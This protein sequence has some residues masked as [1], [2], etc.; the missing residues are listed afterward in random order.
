MV[1]VPCLRRG[2]RCLPETHFAP[3]TQ[4]LITA[5]VERTHGPRLGA[6]HL[7]PEEIVGSPPLCGSM[8]RLLDDRKPR[9]SRA[10]AEGREGLAILIIMAGLMLAG[11]LV[12][13]ACL[14]K[15]TNK[16]RHRV[17]TLA[18]NLR[19]TPSGKTGSTSGETVTE[20]ITLEHPT[21][22]GEAIPKHAIKKLK[23]AP[24]PDKNKE[25]G[26]K[27]KASRKRR[28]L[29]AR[30]KPTKSTKRRFEPTD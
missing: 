24:H 17:L 23:A 6:M 27:K 26:S 21:I 22:A 2:S 30:P 20:T 5:T 4:R 8:E 29:K 15:Q 28:N 25:G 18:M 10:E 9:K 12:G 16:D 19:H 11:V 1:C 3:P 13:A 7:D 14:P